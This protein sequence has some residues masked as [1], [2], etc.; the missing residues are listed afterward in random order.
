M[1]GDGIRRSLATVSKEERDLLRDAI[2]Q[3]NRVFYSPTGSRTDFPAGH[4]SMWFKQDEIH[5][6]SHVHGCPAFLPWHRELLNRFEALIR[7]INPRLSL[8]YWDWNL[9]PSNMPDGEGGT[10]N[11]F[12]EHF[13]GNA[14]GSVN[15][16]A[17]GEPL[18]SAGFYKP[19]AVNYRDDVAPVR[20]VRPNPADPS[21][22]SYPD[23][24]SGVHYNPADPPRSLTRDKQSGAPPVGV[25]GAGWATDDEF[26]Q[27]PTWEAFRDLMY[28]D[29]QGTSGFGAHGAAHSY[30]GGNLDDAHISFRDPFVFLMHANI[31]RLWAMWQLHS[32]AQ[33]LDPAQVY[34]TESNTTGSG[35]VEFG[36]P[37]WGILSPLEPWAGYNAQ[38]PATGEIADLWPIRPWFAPEN[39]QNLPEKH[40]NSKDIT[41]VIPPSY[42]TAPP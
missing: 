37:F 29:E 40:K 11:L 30:I 6:S 24:A 39:E 10:I 36:D 7:T 15:G 9:D 4:V 25:A 12:D 35:S 38:T 42:D 31:D 28:G 33:R 2:L 26:I 13:M 3:L 16:G 1:L 14:D 17:V 22:F 32:A 8:H 20:L 23:P 5:Q 18:L 41:V 19:H 27:A 21:T 34:D